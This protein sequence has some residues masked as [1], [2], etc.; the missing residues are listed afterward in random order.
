MVLL[1]QEVKVDLLKKA[2]LEEVNLKIIQQLFLLNLR[3]EEVLQNQAT[4]LL[5]Q[6][7]VHQ[8]RKK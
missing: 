6:E 8:R 7:E 5:N 3:Q 2:S 4:V 1:V